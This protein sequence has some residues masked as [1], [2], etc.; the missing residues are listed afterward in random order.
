MVNYTTDVFEVID[1]YAIYLCC[2]LK[3]HGKHLLTC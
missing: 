2:N 1:L 3:Y